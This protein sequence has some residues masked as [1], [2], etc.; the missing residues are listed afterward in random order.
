MP[1]PVRDIR[2]DVRPEP[3]HRPQAEGAHQ[4]RQHGDHLQHREAHADADTRPGAEG[5][6]G[7]AVARPGSLGREAVGVEAVGILPRRSRAGAG[8]GL[9]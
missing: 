5:Q 8:T 9:R 4:R 3:L 2:L 1:W 6:I 7:A